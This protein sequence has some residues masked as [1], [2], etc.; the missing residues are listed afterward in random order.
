MKRRVVITGVGAVSP[1]GNDVNTMWNAAKNGVCGIDK[2]T[3]FNTENSKVK[4]AA[5]VK[6]FDP[7]LV[8]DKK[9]IRKYA[10]FTQFALFAANEAI[11]NSKLDVKNMDTS[12][13][14]VN[15]SSG[16]GAIDVIETEHSKGLEKGFDRVSP[17]F[18]PLTIVNMAAGSIAIAHG[19]KG[20]CTAVVT[21]CASSTN[22]IGEAFRNIR[23]GYSD[24]MLCGGAEATITPLAMGGFTSIR[25]LSES[26][27]PKR[28]SIPFDAKRQGFVMGEG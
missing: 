4:L 25:A 20:S 6:G 12:R 28:A 1:I 9:E 11:L 27:D 26:E 14:G 13:F 5:E 21:A 23:D 22:A 17:Y 16:I 10:K 7:S 24:I 8:I 19:L 15:F 3:K 2:I 18:I